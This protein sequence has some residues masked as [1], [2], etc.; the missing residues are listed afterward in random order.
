[1]VRDSSMPVRRPLMTR[2]T[3]RPRAWSGARLAANGT[4]ICATT[5]VAPLTRDASSSTGKLVATP[6]TARAPGGD[7]SRQGNDP[8]FLQPIAQRTQEQHADH[9]T[10][11]VTVI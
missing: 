2:P 9:V 7:A 10:T 1:M 11:C 5:D 8:G 6:A 4:R 3:I